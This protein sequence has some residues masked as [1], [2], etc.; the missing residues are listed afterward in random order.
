VKLPVHP[1]EFDRLVDLADGDEPRVVKLLLDHNCDTIEV[2]HILTPP[3]KRTVKITYMG[4]E[5]G[6]DE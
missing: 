6:Q 3:G 1:G 2:R 4:K 5:I